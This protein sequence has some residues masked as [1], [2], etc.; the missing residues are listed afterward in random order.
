MNRLSS[1]ARALIDRVGDADGPSLEDR[2]RIRASLFGTLAAGA[3]VAGSTGLA[4]GAQAGTG[5][6]RAA[7]TAKVAAGTSVAAL[8]GKGT[9]AVVLWFVAGGVAGTAIATPVAF[10]TERPSRCSLRRRSALSKMWNQRSSAARHTRW[11]Q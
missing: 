6:A 3:T 8:A 4:F 5:V 1:G 10:Y 9:A 11:G 7:T 2:E